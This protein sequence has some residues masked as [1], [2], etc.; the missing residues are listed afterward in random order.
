M[1]MFKIIEIAGVQLQLSA[2]SW[3]MDSVDAVREMKKTWDLGWC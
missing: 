1:Y 2:G 3:G